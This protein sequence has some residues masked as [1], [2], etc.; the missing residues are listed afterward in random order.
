ML[1][2]AL[3]LFGLFILSVFTVFAEEDA[4]KRGDFWAAPGF[5]AASYSTQG[6]AY[7][8]SLTIGYGSG[9][10]IGLKLA[11]FI[12]GD[13]VDTLEVSFL[14]RFYLSGRDVYS[15]AFIQVMGGPSVFNRSGDAFLPSYSG[16]LS[17]GLCFGWRFVFN[18]RWFIEPHVRS[19]VPYILGVGVCAGV[20]F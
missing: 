4:G 15:G 1:K 7:G 16:T 9:S 10:M 17:A 11:Y 2:K 8:G 5:E 3:L 13:D 6:L 12:S 18:D 19:G 20:R 14:L